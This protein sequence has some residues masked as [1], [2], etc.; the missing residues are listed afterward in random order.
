M[1]QGRWQTKESV[2]HAHRAGEL[3]D[4]ITEAVATS[5]AMNERI[6]AAAEALADVSARVRENIANI[7]ALAQETSDYAEGS[8][9]NARAIETTA[10]SL[11]ELVMR[12]K[13]R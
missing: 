10:Q 8:A 2:Q 6:A 3:L 4:H 9:E 12:F 7:N 13:L 1:E 5:T 11:T